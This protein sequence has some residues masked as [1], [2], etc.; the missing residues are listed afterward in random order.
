MR[1]ALL[2]MG[3]LG[4][5][6]CA[7][8]G[9]RAIAPGRGV[10]AEVVNKTEDEQILTLIVRNR[11]DE[12]VGMMSVAGIVASLS[13][14]ANV[15]VNVGF[16][17]EDSYSG[18]LVPLSGGV[19]YE[20]NPTISYVPL[21]GE[22]FLRKMLSPVSVSQMILLS[23]MVKNHGSTFDIMAERVNGLRNPFIGEEPPSP[24]FLRLVAL[25][26]QLRQGAVLD[27]IRAAENENEYFITIH[28]YEEAY[29]DTVR[30]FLDLLGIERDADGNEIVL[31]IHSAV[32]SSD[33]AINLLPRSALDILRI[34]GAGVDIPP[35]HLEA[36]IVQPI[37]WE[38][39]EERRPIAIRSSK[40]RPDEATVSILFRDWWFYI[41]ATDT[42]SKLA[43]KLIR[44]FIGMR[45]EAG[46]GVQ[47]RLPVLTVPVK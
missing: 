22:T 10:Y 24:A 34:Y 18:N 2:V 6:G 30:D 13:F 5:L 29:S 25:Y 19:A 46:G 1:G 8:V 17:P 12:T 28:D 37:K 45:L 26:T 4:S 36:G 40:K 38:V 41:D 33:S 47:Q 15:G 16:G 43:F 9:Y 11:Y 32:G 3:A 20:E 23:S 42:R 27:V 7:T 21:S 14:R 35:P 39:S 31:P 44:T